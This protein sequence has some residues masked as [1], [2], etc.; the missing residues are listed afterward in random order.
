MLEIFVQK[1]PILYLSIYYDPSIPFFRQKKPNYDRL[2]L[3]QAH[4]TETLP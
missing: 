3:S 2:L 1:K 4:A